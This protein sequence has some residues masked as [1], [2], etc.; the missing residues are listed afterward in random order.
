MRLA[1]TKRTVHTAD[2]ERWRVGRRWS[3][4]W[5]IAWRRKRGKGDGFD[6]P[7]VDL[8]TGGGGHHGGGGSLNHGGGGG[9]FDLG[10]VGDDLV[11]GVVLLVVVVVVVIVLFPV[12]ELLIAVLL[13]FFAVAGRVVLRRPWTVEARRVSGWRG[14][15]VGRASWSVVGLRRSGA[16]AREIA[17]ALEAT[18]RFPERPAGAE[19]VALPPRA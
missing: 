6:L 19:P 3:S 8:P 7:D 13:L 1:G 5:W 18:G 9:G 11:I 12:I 17:E 15:T 16:A 14:K 10:D 4:S 2:G